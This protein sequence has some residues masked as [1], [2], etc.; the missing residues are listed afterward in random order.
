MAVSLHDGVRILLEIDGKRSQPFRTLVRRQR[1]HRRRRRTAALYQ[2]PPASNTT[3]DNIKF[4]NLCYSSSSMSDRET[5]V[6]APPSRSHVARVQICNQCECSIATRLCPGKSS[7]RRRNHLTA[8]SS[9]SALTAEKNTPCG[10]SQN[11]R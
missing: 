6:L 9:A 4:C 11:T 1:R 3:N 10:P 5:V 7:T 8:S 2:S